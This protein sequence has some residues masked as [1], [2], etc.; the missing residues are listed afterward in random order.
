MM[1][2]VLVVSEPGSATTVYVN[3]RRAG[4]THMSLPAEIYNYVERIEQRWP[5]PIDELLRAERVRRVK[6]L[7]SY[8]EARFAPL[9]ERPAPSPRPSSTTP[10][11]RGRTDREPGR[12]RARSCDFAR[13]G[14][15]SRRPAP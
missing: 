6:G 12:R 8:T 3:G 10:A 5:D 4:M 11:R 1:H 9:L 2:F 13:T 14:R 7:P 15:C